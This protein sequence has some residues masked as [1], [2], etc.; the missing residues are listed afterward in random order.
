M[1]KP[2]PALRCIPDAARV[3]QTLSEA[4]RTRLSEPRVTLRSVAAE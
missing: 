2:Q 3:A 4:A 1:E